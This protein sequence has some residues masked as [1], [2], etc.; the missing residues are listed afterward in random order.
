MP[1]PD[2]MVIHYKVD[3]SIH[4]KC[5]PHGGFRENVLRLQDS[6]GFT[7]WET[8]MSEGCGLNVWK[9]NIF[10][11]WEATLAKKENTVLQGQI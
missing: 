3:L 8:W 7:L 9:D 5:Q 6:L 10:I 4:G 11:A 2:V 1:A